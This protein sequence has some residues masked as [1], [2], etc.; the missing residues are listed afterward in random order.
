MDSELQEQLQA[1]YHQKHAG[2]PALTLSQ[3]TNI[4]TGWECEVYSFVLER[5]SPGQPAR[6]ELILRLYPGDD[7]ASKSEKEFYVLSQLYQASYPVPRVD[8][9][10][11]DPSLLGKPFIIMEK[12]DG[13]EMWSLMDRAPVE[14]AK[15]LLTLFTTLY[16]RLH[17]LDWRLF[18]K[19]SPV[20]PT[21]SPYAFID[22][23]I[24]FGRKVI[25]ESSVQ[26]FI[27]V[28]EWVAARRDQVPCDRPVLAHFDYHPANLLVR[29]DGTALV[30]DWTASAVLDPRFDLAWT[31][32][33][34]WMYAGKDARDYIFSEYERLS[35]SPVR[36]IAVFEVIA[37][38]RR[39][40]DIMRSVSLGAEKMGM[41]PGAEEIMK[42]QAGPIQKVYEILVGH[43]GIRVPEIEAFIQSIML[44]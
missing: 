4:T 42:K 30:I 43:T 31:S 18:A 21:S 12:I 10:E 27:P 26:G 19:L 29:E 2:G 23:F 34:V 16:V 44:K 1:Y 14:R 25:G 41:R 11:K 22:W 40:S 39:L 9:L 28:L 5:Q 6:E 8:H 32:L 33:L 35:G 38:L 37:C 20:D 36:E 13:K 17:R 15:A 24:Q 3:L 7:G